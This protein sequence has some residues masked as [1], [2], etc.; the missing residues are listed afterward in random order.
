MKRRTLYRLLLKSE[1]G[2]YLLLFSTLAPVAASPWLAAT[3]P[4]RFQLLPWPNKLLRL[5]QTLGV[6]DGTHRRMILL[7]HWRTFNEIGEVHQCRAY[8][9]VK[10]VLLKPDTTDAVCKSVS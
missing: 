7:K 6:V 1:V 8:E 3:L 5:Q 9:H 2:N 10:M 4:Q